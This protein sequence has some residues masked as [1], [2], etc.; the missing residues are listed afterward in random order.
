MKILSLIFALITLSLIFFSCHTELVLGQYQ[1]EYN[2][3]IYADGSATWTIKQIGTN[4]Q[5]SPDTYSAFVGKVRSLIEAAKNQ[6]G[7]NMTADN[8]KI[9]ADVSGSYTAVKYQFDW[10]NFSKIEHER[11]IIG[12]VFEADVFSLLYS[13][14]SLYITYPSQYA[15]ETVSPIPPA[16]NAS[17]QILEWYG[18]IDFKRGEPKIVLREKSAPPEFTDIIRQNAI[19]ITSLAAL[20]AGFSASLYIFKRNKKK[21]SHATKMPEYPNLLGIESD[22]DKIVKLLESAGGSLY[23]SAISDQCKFSRAKTSQL[24]TNLEK[25]GIVKRYK[26]G[27]EKV[28]IVQKG[29]QD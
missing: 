4:I 8:L 6:T 16:Q 24:L 25:Q 7:R 11:I 23:Q 5:V 18:T 3:Q 12:D 2:I 15:V 26:K 22:K 13:D 29:R 10:K 27:R 20:T 17:L 19:L 1:L 28:V 9:T 14:G 21:I